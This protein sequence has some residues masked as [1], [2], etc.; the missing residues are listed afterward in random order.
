MLVFLALYLSLVGYTLS[1]SSFPIVKNRY[2]GSTSCWIRSSVHDSGG[3]DFSLRLLP[4]TRFV[5]LPLSYPGVITAPFLTK[6]AVVMTFLYPSSGSSNN[7]VEGILSLNPDLHLAH[8][9]ENCAI[10]RAT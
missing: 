2:G 1:C 9:A 5:D 7:R 8:Q 10:S 6:L 3:M 4:L